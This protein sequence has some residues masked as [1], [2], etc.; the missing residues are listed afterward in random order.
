M[1]VFR[2]LYLGMIGCLVLLLEIFWVFRV[3]DVFLSIGPIPVWLDLLWNFFFL[4]HSM[5]L[6]NGIVTFESFPVFF[7]SF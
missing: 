2:N 1:N 7:C 3:L 6:G 4:L 5:V